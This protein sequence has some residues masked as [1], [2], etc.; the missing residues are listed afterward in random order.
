[1]N[2]IYNMLGGCIYYM[3]DDVGAIITDS[4]TFKTRESQQSE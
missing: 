3:L 1:M 2:D 4:R